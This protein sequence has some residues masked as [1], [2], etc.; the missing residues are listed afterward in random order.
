ML[1][2]DQCTGKQAGPAPLTPQGHSTASHPPTPPLPPRAPSLAPRLQRFLRE[3]R[4]RGV[5]AAGQ[6]GP[7]GGRDAAPPKQL[8]QEGAGPREPA[9]CVGR[10]AEQVAVQRRST[11]SHASQLRP[12]PPLPPLHPLPSANPA[13]PSLTHR[14]AAAAWRPPPPGGAARRGRGAGRARCWPCWA[15]GLQCSAVQCSAPGVCVCGGGAKGQGHGGQGGYGWAGGPLKPAESP[16]P[17]PVPAERTGSSSITP[18]QQHR[19]LLPQLV[20]HIDRGVALVGCHLGGGARLLDRARQRRGGQV[21]G[22][23]VAADLLCKVCVGGGRGAR[24]ARDR[25]SV[26][27]HTQ[28]YTHIPHLDLHLNTHTRT[29]MHTHEHTHTSTLCAS[30]KISTASLHWMLRPARVLASSK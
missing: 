8:E 2:M 16:H 27:P 9:V 3:H 13:T 6:H 22:H 5:Q 24:G 19:T 10:G 7:G 26:S 20:E 1:R 25:S 29:H 12:L 4:H 15:C 18:Q 11:P 28:T 23:R 17:R 21:E 14:G 30:S